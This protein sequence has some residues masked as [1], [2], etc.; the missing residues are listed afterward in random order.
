M[1][2]PLGRPPKPG[3]R[4]A[5]FV[6]A[7][8][9]CIL[10]CFGGKM[11]GYP[12]GIFYL[13]SRGWVSFISE[14]WLYLVSQRILHSSPREFS[15]RDLFERICKESYE[16]EVSKR[17]ES[18]QREFI[19]RGL[20]ERTQREFSKRVLRGSDQREFSK[21]VLKKIPSPQPPYQL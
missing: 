1:R 17:E 20:K 7:C 10:C 18:S 8:A 15:K 14:G 3:N 12:P 4:F 2:P 19:Q 16:K 21:R 5:S 9:R 6:R 11:S 13:L